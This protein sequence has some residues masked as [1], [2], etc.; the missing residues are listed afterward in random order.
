MGVLIG[1]FP[2]AEAAV[3]LTLNYQGRLLD[4]NGIPKADGTYSFKISIYDA[5]T[6][7]TCQYTMRGTCV[8]PTAESVTV[9]DGVFS[10]LIGD[11][12]DNAIPDSLFNTS[13]LFLGI[14]IDSDSEMAPRK[15]IVAAPYA[16]NANRLDNY[17]TSTT[18]TSTASVVPVTD[19]N[20]NLVLIGNP[21]G[22]GVSQGSLYLNPASAN[23]ATDET[24]L[25]IAVG[26]SNRFIVD[27]EGDLF[28]SGTLRLEGTGT[29]TLLGHLAIQ[30][31]ARWG[32]ATTDLIDVT[33]RFSTSLLP[34][35]NNTLD[36]GAF[37]NAWRDIYAS[38]TLRVGSTA[39]LN[40]NSLEFSASGTV[41]TTGST[42]DLS[43]LPGRNLLVGTSTN[44]SA[45][46]SIDTLADATK[47]IVVRGTVN[48]SG[49]LQE[50][51]DGSGTILLRIAASGNVFPGS[52]NA[53]EIGSSAL[54]FANIWTQTLTSRSS[55]NLTLDSKIDTA[56]TVFLTSGDHLASL[57]NNNADLGQF[58][59]AFR[60][61]FASGTTRLG[62]LSTDGNTTLGDDATVDTVTLNARFAS[63][64]NPST[65][66]TID[67]GAF[68]TAFRDIYASS[69]L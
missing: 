26:G 42:S 13:D 30:G 31:N 27:G 44:L 19:S 22:A 63:T 1:N 57:G 68:G 49:A 12:S 55:T 66:N 65:N 34:N 5:A 47:G 18:G 6:G 24:L 60:N 23:V 11:S 35:Q 52:D 15:Q 36:L 21:Q 29:S 3:P 48:Q 62:V 45:K 25:G 20:G 17:D 59:F 14:T 2:T 16:L 40:T 67:L 37:A 8:T 39:T 53:R 33:G 28:A 50:W 69:S 61:I 9:T 46:L 4:S 32:D 54:S 38:G 7:G 64:M 43:L 56:G 58:A 10:I 51:Q 41:S